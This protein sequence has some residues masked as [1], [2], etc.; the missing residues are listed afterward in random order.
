MRRFP[1]QTVQK[2]LQSLKS[3]VRSGLYFQLLILTLTTFNGYADTNMAI[4]NSPAASAQYSMGYFVATSEELKDITIDSEAL[5]MGI[6]DTL[7]G[8]LQ[9]TPKEM[10]QALENLG[11]SLVQEKNSTQ[12]KIKAYRYDNQRFLQLN[13]TKMGIVTTDS[14]L[15]YQ[16]LKAGTG[17]APSL[18]DQIL[19]HYSGS[20]INGQ[21]FERS[22]HTQEPTNVT[23]SEVIPGWSEALQLMHTGSQWRLF[24]PAELAYGEKGVEHRIPPYSTLILDVE[25]L[26]IN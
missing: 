15:Q 12:E 26:A 16:V 5:M 10:Q 25:L 13:K 24:I 20:L 8:E 19:V 23:V 4:L 14:G 18:N 7:T 1:V 2:S 11:Q 17:P 21:P 3:S 6:K 9:L 22:Y